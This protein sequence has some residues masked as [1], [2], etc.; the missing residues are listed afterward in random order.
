[1]SGSLSPWRTALHDFPW[2]LHDFPWT[3]HDFPWV[4]R[5][6]PLGLSRRQDRCSMSGVRPLYLLGRRNPYFRMRKRSRSGF[7]D[8]A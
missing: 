5:D 7:P 6:F 2:I 8:K 3:V 1:M 4:L